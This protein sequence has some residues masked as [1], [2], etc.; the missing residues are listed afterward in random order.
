[1]QFQ[2]RD[3]RLTANQPFSLEATCNMFTLESANG[4]ITLQAENGEFTAQ[5]GR[6]YHADTVGKIHTITSTLTETITITTGAGW[7]LQSRPA[8]AGDVVLD[9]DQEIGPNETL[10]IP[11]NGYGTLMLELTV[12]ATGSARLF[13]LTTGLDIPFRDRAGNVYSPGVLPLGFS[14]VIIVDLEATGGAQIAYFGP[15]G[16][17]ITVSQGV[18]SALPRP[19]SWERRQALGSGLSLGGTP[20]TGQQIGSTQRNFGFKTVTVDGEFSG[21][22]PVDVTLQP[23]DGDGAIY[24]GAPSGPVSVPSGKR[25][26]ISYDVDSG[27]VSYDV[28]G[29]GGGTLTGLAVGADDFAIVLGGPAGAWGITALT[30]QGIVR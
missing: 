10:D 18:L 6:E 28:F 8:P 11:S 13:S 9:V 4:T 23:V 19:Y 29:V 17:F 20:Y 7:T 5:L 1:M 15:P 3:I 16:Q 30:I 24:L 14:G 12:P 27:T 21:A 2:T 26:H 22:G 25:F